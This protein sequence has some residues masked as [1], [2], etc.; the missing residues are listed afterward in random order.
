FKDWK[1][2]LEHFSQRIDLFERQG[3]EYEYI[4]TNEDVPHYV[5]A[6][7]EKFSYMLERRGRPNAGFIDVNSL[8]PL[9]E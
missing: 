9:D 2:I 6:N 8:S 7:R 5:L 4:A 1:W 3:E